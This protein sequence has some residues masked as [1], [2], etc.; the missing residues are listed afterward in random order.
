[1]FIDTRAGVFLLYII[2]GSLM[3]RHY[4]PFF[5]P[6]VKWQWGRVC[7]WVDRG[8]PSSPGLGRL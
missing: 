4:E 1:M 2:A 8:L 7:D 5:L 6:R 3:Y